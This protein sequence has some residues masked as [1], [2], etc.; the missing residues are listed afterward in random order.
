VEVTISVMIEFV[1]V[2]I[3]ISDIVEIVTSMRDFIEIIEK[4]TDEVITSSNRLTLIRQRALILSNNFLQALRF[5]SI[6]KTS[7]ILSRILT[8]FEKINFS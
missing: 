3:S 5:T 6:N 2:I 4:I 8:C 1:E 7:T